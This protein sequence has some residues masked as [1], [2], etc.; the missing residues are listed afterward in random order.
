MSNA[1]KEVFYTAKQINGFLLNINK[2]IVQDNFRPD[3]IIGITRGG[4]VPA[5]KLSHYL[6]VPMYALSEE[7]SNLWMA[8]DEKGASVP[9]KRKNILIIDDINDTGT[10]LNNLKNDWQSGCMPHNGAWNDVWHRNVKFAVLIDNEASA[11]NSDYQGAT[12][13]KFENPEWCV[14][15]WENWWNE[16]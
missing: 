5:I 1:V 8:I 3:Y 13:N 9:T 10:T 14:F 4:L 12:I 11:F 7:E 2:Q 16:Q 15:P 6:D